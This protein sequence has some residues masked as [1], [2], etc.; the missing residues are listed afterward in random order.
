MKRW[1]R[2]ADGVVVNV[3]EAGSKPAGNWVEVSG[4]FGPG[5]LY[6]GANFSHP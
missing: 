6:D 2:I 4:P 1:A 5:D 3:V